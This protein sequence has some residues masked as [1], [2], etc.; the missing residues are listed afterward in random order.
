M[1]LNIYK[2]RQVE[3]TY[4]AETYD[5]MF[6]TIEDVADAINL[7]SLKTGSDVEIIKM[8]GN[9]VLHS[10]DTVKNLLKDIFEGIT[11]EELKR[12]KVKEIAT[13]LL[14]VVK[15]TIAQLNLG[16]NGKN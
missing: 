3:K 2:G 6:G 15:F 9:L 12:T 5:L 13:V 11:D 14:D 10:M 7:D 1:K 8:I 16:N 4:T